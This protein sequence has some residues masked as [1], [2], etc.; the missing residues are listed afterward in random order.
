[1]QIY[2]PNNQT[3]RLPKWI[4]SIIPY[5]RQ[6]IMHLWHGKIVLVL[7]RKRKDICPRRQYN[8]PVHHQITM[9]FQKPWIQ[10]MYSGGK[11][12]YNLPWFSSLGFTCIFL[13]AIF[14]SCPFLHCF[15][16][17]KA[18]KQRYFYMKTISPW[19]SCGMSLRWAWAKCSPLGIY[20]QAC[21]GMDCALIAEDIYLC[22]TILFVCEGVCICVCTHDHICKRCPKVTLSSPVGSCGPGVDPQFSKKRNISPSCSAQRRKPPSQDKKIHYYALGSNEISSYCCP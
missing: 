12:W 16:M 7:Q 18:K 10:I 11:Y 1:M 13:T 17:L 2:F 3:W 4:N 8:R 19:C 15:D 20:I 6:N 14:L 21:R 22:D 9:S 5:D